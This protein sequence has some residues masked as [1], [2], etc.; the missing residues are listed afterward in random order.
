MTDE[1]P[2]RYF[3]ITGDEPDVEGYGPALGPRREH[4]EYEVA[5]GVTFQP[6]YGRNV[7]LNFVTFGPGTGFPR[8]QH[9]EEQLG[10]VVDGEMQLTI[11]AET[12]VAHAGDVYVIPPNVHHAGRTGDVACVVLDIFA[13]PRSGF[14]ELIARALAS[15]VRPRWD[16][17]GP[18]PD[19]GST[20]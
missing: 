2:E 3:R 6:V 19:G 20:A 1:R 9:P 8:H 15:P 10:M 18:E 17:L 11:G 14:R 5:D 4:P 13:P 16:E 7:L 12:R